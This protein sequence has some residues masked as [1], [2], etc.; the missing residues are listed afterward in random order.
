MELIFTPFQE[1]IFKDSIIT[2]GVE[3]QLDQVQE[4]AIELAL[5]IRKYKRAKQAIAYTTPDEVNTRTRE[6]ISEI[7]DVIIMTQQCRLIFSDEEIKSEIQRK[8]ERQRQ[9]LDVKIA[10]RMTGTTLKQF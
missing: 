3:C 6:L 7:A 2:Y 8:L 5:A 4:E 9:R 1:R 10:K